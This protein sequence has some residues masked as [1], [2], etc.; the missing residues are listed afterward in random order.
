M[1]KLVQYYRSIFASILLLTIYRRE[2]HGEGVSISRGRE[3]C[4]QIRNEA[5]KVSGESKQKKV[6]EAKQKLTT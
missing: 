6:V 3:L 2:Q 1:Y 4:C 5:D